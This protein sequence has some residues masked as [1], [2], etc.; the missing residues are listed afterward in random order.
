MIHSQKIFKPD[1]IGV[2]ASSLCLIH[3]VATPFLFVAKACSITCCSDSPAWW[4]V[5][6][7]IFIAIS[8][9]AILYATKNSTKKWIQIALWSSWILLLVAILSESFEI[10]LFPK[11]FAYFPALT[12]IGFHFYNLKYCK[13]SK[14]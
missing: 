9:I 1:F 4:R 10:G 8:F 2:L 14:E 12:I 11:S 13:H 6:D 7:Y 5:I 3:C